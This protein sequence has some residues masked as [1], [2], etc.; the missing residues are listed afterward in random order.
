MMF[1][2][3]SVL[4]LGLFACS[5]P[6]SASQVYRVRPSNS[7][8]V[9]HCPSETCHTLEYYVSRAVWSLNLES[10][11]A[12]YFMS[13]VH[14]L[15]HP[16]NFERVN[17]LSIIG[18]NELLHS[19]L[20]QPSSEIR[21]SGS[22]SLSFSHITNLLVANLSIINCGW[23]TTYLTYY[24]VKLLY[25]S[26]LT[27]SSVV[28]RNG[29]GNG[30]EFY[31]VI[32]NSVISDSLFAYNGWDENHVGLNALVVFAMQEDDCIAYT[33]DSV[34]FTIQ[35][36]QFLHG[37]NT[38]S[39]PN[40]HSSFSAG[41]E[42]FQLSSCLNFNIHVSEVVMSCNNLEG[43]ERYGGNVAITV[44]EH[45]N[46]TS[47]TNIT[48]E[49]SLI[50]KGKA[51]IAG[52]AYIGFHN[53]SRG[54]CQNLTRKRNIIRIINSHIVDNTATEDYGGLLVHFDKVCQDYLLEI[55]G[56]T[57]SRN[58]AASYP[59]PHRY[60]AGNT[61]GGSSSSDTSNSDTTD[62]P[63]PRTILR[64]NTAP[65]GPRTLPGYKASGGNRFSDTSGSAI[66]VKNV[67]GNFAVVIDEREYP[68][69]Q[70]LII[71]E[72]CHIEQGVASYAGGAQINISNRQVV[73][74]PAGTQ[75]GLSIILK[76]SN[77][78]FIGNTATESFGGLWVYVT[79]VHDHVYQLHM[80]GIVFRENNVRENIVKLKTGSGGN[81]VIH[82]NSVFTN[83][84]LPTIKIEN[85]TFD[86]G[87]A[88]SG[89]GM[90]LE[91]GIERSLLFV[92]RDHGTWIMIS[93]SHFINNHG[94]AGGGV[95]V[96][97]K[98]S[99]CNPNC[100]Q[101]IDFVQTLIIENCLF[102]RNTGYLGSALVIRNVDAS[103]SK[104]VLYNYIWLKNVSFTNNHPPWVQNYTNVPL[105]IT[106]ED[107]IYATVNENPAVYLYRADLTVSNSVFSA[108]NI[109]ALVAIETK[110]Y[111]VGDIVF[112]NNTGNRGGGLSL[113]SSY[114][115][116]ETSTNLQF[117]NNHAKQVGGAIYVEQDSL[118]SPCFIQPATQTDVP[119]TNSTVAIRCANNTAVEAG[120]DL[121]GG[122]INL[123]CGGYINLHYG[124]YLTFQTIIAHEGEM[125]PS[126]IS[127][128]PI[129]TCFCKD[130]KPNCNTS[131]H[132]LEAY[133]GDIFNV[134]IV[135]VGQWDGTVPGVVHAVITDNGVANQHSLPALQQSQSV[136]GN[137]TNLTYSVFSASEDET[138]QLTV[139]NPTLSLLLLK[140]PNVIKVKLLR[141]PLGFSLH[142]SPAKC[143][144][145]PPLNESKSFRCSIHNQSIHYPE[146]MW[147]GYYSLDYHNPN[148]SQTTV[149]IIPTGIILHNH[150]P[151][152][153]CN[154]DFTDIIL[155]QQNEQCAF[156]RSGI[157]CGGCS[158]GFS[159]MLGSSQCI[160][161]SNTNLALVIA[162]M[163]AGPML[164]AFLT[165]C[166]LTVAEGT[167]GA[168]IFYA[169][170]MQVNSPI[171]FPS[172][173]AN[174]L[175][176]TFIAWVNLDLGIKVCFYDGLDMY[177][178]AWLQFVFPIYIWVI[179]IIM[180]ISSYYST[181][182]AKM[183]S[184][185]APKVL[186]TLFL[187]SYAKLLRIAITVLSFTTMEYPD[188]TKQLLWLPDGN[189]G[190]L[191]GKHIPLFIA[192]LLV[193]WCGIPNFGT[194]T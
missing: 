14:I 155:Q 4:V 190:Y 51:A 22:N 47:S 85:C 159:L 32:G 141:C 82:A 80:S 71:I 145:A 134:S 181:T 180:I 72:N 121:Y 65:S 68:T 70:H 26:N 40:T 75:M 50:E 177:T 184:R 156:N 8:T 186:A 76:I 57:L 170:I 66:P 138:I 148:S 183:V 112:S 88:G 136:G 45:Q 149:N 105:V 143:D 130:S 175:L 74:I 46:T 167:L 89:A 49:K 160:K 13:G 52:G 142:R 15:K 166:N 146:G 18:S 188:H 34:S 126:I 101:E 43:R 6:A 79:D 150:C 104:P 114:I 151:F 92:G 154:P 128:D 63:E 53:P 61:A 9:T 93:N 35:S 147:I 111:L 30:I 153:Y 48:I 176:S 107:Q 173:K 172:G 36:S 17:N 132:N 140:P 20:L 103:V 152:D 37:N 158:P 174:I 163:A 169:N 182:A 60:E 193:L 129:G 29:S 106:R 19:L 115:L 91:L 100:S 98:G 123:S 187:L 109:T 125:G 86:S 124:G 33:S 55:M 90:E 41:L 137:C 27:M 54:P 122:Y 11:T 81:L 16:L 59:G 135:V 39:M 64:K 77:T 56:T 62:V 131:V 119:D 164:V 58:T 162:F 171:F 31:N 99:W 67:G 185:N 113:K 21:C 157:L 24:A 191:R 7:E 83:T 23:G 120:S 38:T 102:T 189:L 118:N 110:L 10:N 165:V 144:C 73:P 179:V 12:I 127:S 108:N 133:P 161:C 192:A 3:R 116:L 95:V 28:I 44:M 94:F 96:N 117:L 87:T 42:V 1:M 178:K 25:I 139:D 194:I 5:S 84:F 97:L 69:S 168:L 2:I 78:T